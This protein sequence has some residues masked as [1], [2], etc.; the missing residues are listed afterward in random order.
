MSSPQRFS[1][2]L[3]S[4][5]SSGVLGELVDPVLPDVL[6]VPE[7]VDPVVLVPECLL[8]SV[9]DVLSDVCWEFPAVEL[10][11]VEAL[12]LPQETKLRDMS[13]NKMDCLIFFFI[14]FY[15]PK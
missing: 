7:V 1:S 10:D 13:E 12:V 3:G 5:G 6:V 14:A 9:R 4:S 15:P 11:G 2:S 8:L